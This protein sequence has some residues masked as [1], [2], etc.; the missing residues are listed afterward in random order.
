MI[1][2]T[3]P[4][5]A[6]TRSLDPTAFRPLLGAL[7]ALGI[8]LAAQAGWAQE[9]SP[10]KVEAAA[11]SE[12]SDQ[13]IITSHGYSYF[14]NL[15]YP[16]DFDHFDFANADAPKGGEIVLGA[17]GTFDSMNPYS[18]KGRAGALTTLQYDSLIES[19]E[20]SVGQYYGLLAESLE[21]PEDKSWVIFHIRPEAK[22]W[23]GTP[24]TAED[25]VYSHKLFITQ[26]LP[27]YAAAVGEMVTDAEALDERTVKFTFN[28]ELTK[29]SRIETVGATPVFKKAWFEEDPEKRR[30]DEPRMEVAVGS[31]PYK[32]DSYEVN[33]RIVYKL[34][35]DYWGKD[36]PFN[37]GRHNYGTVRVEY[38]ADQTASFEAFKAGEYTF[39][40]ESD[41]RL[42]ATAY[43]FPRI[44][45]GTVKKEEI[46]DGSPPNPTGF[47]FNLAKPQLKDKNV[48]EAI[49]L[50]FN[51]EWTNESLRYGLYS[52]R[53]SFVEGT[54]VEAKGLPEG[55]ELEF[56]KSL[57]DVVPEDLY[58]TDVWT[59]HE[60]DP[61]D[62]I[63]RRTRR[64]ATRLL[65]EAGWTV[66][67]DGLA[68]NEA[69]KTLDLA[70]IIP[71][72]I[73]SSVEAMHETYVQNL[74][75]IGVNASYEKVDP[76][77]Y[78]LRQR[79][80][81]YDMIYSSRYGAFLSTG[82]G[83]SQ[84]YGSREA[85][86]SLFN[87]AGL[88]S[89]LV[90][91][92]IAA[93]FEA[94]SQEETDVA[95]MALDRALRYEFFIVPDGYIADYWVAYYDMYEHP[96]TIPPYDLGYL[97]LWWVNP[98]KEKALKE[99]GVLN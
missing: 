12:A 34:R 68:R 41:P 33:R 22:F 67:E 57:G 62:L 23:D 32:L 7:T 77:Q 95:L 56:L 20:D 80:R 58:T 36:I 61:E 74:R 42:W 45:Q 69:G 97:S 99:A 63:S 13:Q 75:A 15:D 59:M 85:E 70:M 94:D 98:D 84:M 92:I 86:F 54:P 25:V 46:A 49:S 30:L 73:E 10:E 64:E 89:P 17:S 53:S 29:R 38:F 87:P 66:G 26:G 31:G 3:R 52:P 9:A 40:V 47:V 19:A 39:R 88:A 71:S 11:T 93:S 76:S 81:D 78:T 27:S 2:T 18:R 91:A 50:A 5:A 82:G 24:V 1:R 28:T 96:E 8:A 37:K 21:Y 43:D 72:N 60:S 51:F 90:D 55:K 79:E 48:R 6:A 35:D 4:A 16:A 44:Q 14:G 83:L 65:Q